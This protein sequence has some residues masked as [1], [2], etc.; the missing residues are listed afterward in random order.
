MPGPGGGSSGGGFGGGSRGGGFGGGGFGGGHRGPHYGG[1]GFGP[2]FYGGGGCLGSLLGMILAPVI[3][4]LFVVLFL[5]SSITSTVGILADGGVITYNEKDFQSYANSEYEKAFGASPDELYEDHLLIV[6]TTYED[7]D[8]YEC[9]AWIGDNVETEIS[10]MFGAEGSVFYRA[11]RGS[12]NED[13]Y[14]NSMTRDLSSVMERMT[15]E[16]KNLGLESSFRKEYD[17][18]EAPE[19]KL[20]NYTELNINDEI[21]NEVLAEFTEETGISAVIVVDTGEKVFGKTMPFSIIFTTLLLLVVAGLC[22]YWIIKAVKNKKKGGFGGNS[23]QN[24]GSGGYGNGGYGN[25]GGYSQGN[26]SR[27]W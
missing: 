5:F 18:T 17:H 8:G 20:V 13:Y 27:F 10:D 7:Y 9:I 12:I 22:V 2:R 19:S 1:F 15:K 25:G 3:L 6:F 21:V 24:G 14:E 26:N 16:I 11:V 23:N 4:L